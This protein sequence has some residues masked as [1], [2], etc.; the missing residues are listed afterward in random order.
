MW[1]KRLLGRS[2][3]LSQGE[4]AYLQGILEV[5]ARGDRT[6]LRQ[7][8]L[9]NPALLRGPIFNNEPLLLTAVQSRNAASVEVLLLCGAEANATLPQCRISAL[10]RAA[11]LGAC[12]V[13]ATLLAYG[14][15]INARDD[16]G[17]TPLHDATTYGHP[18]MVEFLLQDGADPYARNKE[19]YTP[20][21]LAQFNL[22]PK[23]AADLQKQWDIAP[24][25]VQAAAD[26]L[27]RHG[28]HS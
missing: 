14:A 19:G 24:A 5:V 13:A 8:V 25:G 4:K 26:V 11:A 9:D 15:D 21:A 12:E 27:R 10:H 1:L 23:R 18:D 17:A 22:E 16:L 7:M 2:D 6:A 20:L 3:G 28:A